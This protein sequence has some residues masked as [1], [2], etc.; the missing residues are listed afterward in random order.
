MRSLREKIVPKWQLDK[1]LLQEDWKIH[2]VDLPLAEEKL[3]QFNR[4]AHPIVQDVAFWKIEISL[5]KARYK[6]ITGFINAKSTQNLIAG[7]PATPELVDI[8]S[9]I[10]KR[11]E[12]IERLE[13]RLQ[14]S[15]E[16]MSISYMDL[17]I[18]SKHSFEL[19][20]AE[21]QKKKDNV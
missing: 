17:A 19:L 2:N 12:Y 18:R 16:K 20:K 13:E 9:V 5:E 7:K 11:N 10:D 6:A 21:I 3:R 4:L 14:E 8:K 1:S 15:L